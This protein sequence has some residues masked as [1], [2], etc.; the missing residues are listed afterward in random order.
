MTVNRKD[1]TISESEI[2]AALGITGIFASKTNVKNSVRLLRALGITVEWNTKS[3]LE[4][5]R[6]AAI[7]LASEIEEEMERIG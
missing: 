3:N 1:V 2:V 7:K 6:L 5:L 4:R